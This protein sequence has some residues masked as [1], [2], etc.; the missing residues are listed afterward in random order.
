MRLATGVFALMMGGGFTSAHGAAEQQ[1]ERE[2]P[3]ATNE[4]EG[5]QARARVPE[6]MQN[7][8]QRIFADMLADAGQCAVADDPDG[9]FLDGFTACNE[10]IPGDA[11][12]ACAILFS[13]AW[14]EITHSLFWDMETELI[15]LRDRAGEDADRARAEAEIDALGTQRFRHNDAQQQKCAIYYR[16]GDTAEAD[17]FHYMMCNAAQELDLVLRFDEVAAPAK[18]LLADM[19]LSMAKRPDAV[20]PDGTEAQE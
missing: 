9:C 14:G 5:G 2:A 16:A 4:A 7:I 1:R 6:V 3:L 11:A 12:T 17:T 18:R 19:G 20:G 13:T 10:A 15:T 8:M